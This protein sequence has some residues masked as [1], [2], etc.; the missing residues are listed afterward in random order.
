MFEIITDDSH[1][2]FTFVER[3][4]EPTDPQLDLIICWLEVGDPSV[5]LQCQCEFTPYELEKLHNQLSAFYK[6]L[7]EWPLSMQ[8]NFTPRYPVFSLV[9]GKGKDSDCVGFSFRV[10]PTVHDSWS[11]QG[12]MAIEQSY[13]PSLIRGINSILTN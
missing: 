6:H 12:G 8:I 2:R 10:V 7:G 13:F 9:I 4:I 11:L 5:K 1:F 3:M